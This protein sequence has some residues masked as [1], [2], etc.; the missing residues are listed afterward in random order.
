MAGLGENEDVELLVL[1]RGRT[2][3]EWLDEEPTRPALP[4]SRLADAADFLA[5]PEVAEHVRA[6]A[7]LLL[8]RDEALW[9]MLPY[10]MQ[11]K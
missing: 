3:L 4:G 7:G 5:V 10:Q 2:L 8:L 6:A 11:V 1:P 9:T